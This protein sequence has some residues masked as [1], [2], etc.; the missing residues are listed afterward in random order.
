[1]HAIIDITHVACNIYDAIATRTRLFGGS[2]SPN[3]PPG[4]GGLVGEELVVVWAGGGVSAQPCKRVGWG[5]AL[6]GGA[7]W[8]MQPQ[9]SA[10]FLIIRF[11]FSELAR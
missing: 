7:G 11:R 4:A 8:H 5:S 10:S 6:G 3:L 1:M 9:R 2:P